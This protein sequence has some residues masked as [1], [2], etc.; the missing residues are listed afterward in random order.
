MQSSGSALD[1][2]L[3]GDPALFA[4]VWLSLFVSL[5]AVFMAA[6]IGIPVGALL[7]LTRFN[8]REGVIVLVNSLMGL[9]AV[10][11]RLGVYLP[12]LRSG[13]LGWLGLLL[14]PQQ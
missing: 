11:A 1:L 12:L 2:I 13:P 10:V 14:P 5:S 3:A 4:I 8:G 9:P 6:L 7:A